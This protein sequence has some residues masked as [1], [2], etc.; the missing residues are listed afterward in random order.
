ML[1]AAKPEWREFRWD[2]QSNNS[3]SG[4]VLLEDLLL[5]TQVT[6]SLRAR[7]HNQDVNVSWL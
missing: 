4:E 1:P 5:Q 3:R 6:R 2:N 7:S